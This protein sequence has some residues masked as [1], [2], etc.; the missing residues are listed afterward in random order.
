M[1]PIPDG[2]P[3]LTAYLIIDGASD[4]IAFYGKVFGARERMRMPAPGGKVGHAELEFGDALI[5][6]AD[7][8]PDMQIKSPKAYGGS[9]V[10]VN[11]YVEDVD[12]VF[13]AAL[14]AGAK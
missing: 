1:K 11:V 13:A 12:S 4:A 2:Y 5:M 8:F 7:E 10:I 6:L 3:Q 9:P 14:E